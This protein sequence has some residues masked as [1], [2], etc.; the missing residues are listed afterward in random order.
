MT[1]SN[2]TFYRFPIRSIYEGVD[3]NN[4]PFTV[5]YDFFQFRVNV[6]YFN[7]FQ[8]RI[9]TISALFRKFYLSIHIIRHHL[10]F[11]VKI[12]HCQKSNLLRLLKVLVFRKKLF[13]RIGF[14]TFQYVR[15]LNVKKK[16]T[17]I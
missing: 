14:L 5:S 15:I 3:S 1:Y 4:K 10:G 9:L 6:K 11:I 16:N 13:R 12:G 8:V 2:Q 7:E 17:S